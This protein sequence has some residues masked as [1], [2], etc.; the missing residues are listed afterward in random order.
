MASKFHLLPSC[1]VISDTV[2]LQRISFWLFL[3]TWTHWQF[4]T[5][6][7]I[8]FSLN[9]STCFKEFKAHNFDCPSFWHCWYHCIPPSLLPF[10]KSLLLPG[11]YCQPVNSHFLSWISKNRDTELKSHQQELS[12]LV[13]NVSSCSPHILKSLDKKIMEWL[14]KSPH[15]VLSYTF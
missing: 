11:H 7:P 13:Q 1:G 10:L 5:L 14:L 2:P 12:H 6:A 9:C 8:T 4:N 3:L 15:L